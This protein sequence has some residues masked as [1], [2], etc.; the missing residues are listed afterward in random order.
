MCLPRVI[1]RHVI[2]WH[3]S[4]VCDMT[5]PYVTWLIDMWHD[6]ILQES[7]DLYV[8]PTVLQDSCPAKIHVPPRFMSA[9]SHVPPRVLQVRTPLVTDVTWRIHVWRDAFM[10][11]VT[12]SCV[13]WLI[14]VRDSFMTKDLTSRAHKWWCAH[15]GQMMMSW[16]NAVIVQT[17]MLMVS[18]F[19]S[20]LQMI[21]RSHSTND[22][23]LIFY[24]RPCWWSFW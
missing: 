15:I 22:D 8:L 24:K 19:L 2:T 3:D 1:S 12:H 6:S 13:A 21:M 11:G 23:A 10:C 7:C 16:T 14:H 5:H 20:Q 18:C 4:S 9:M 17:T